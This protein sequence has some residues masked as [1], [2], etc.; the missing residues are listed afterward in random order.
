MTAVSQ[1]LAYEI[2]PI[3][4]CHLW[5]GDRGSNGRPIIWRGRRPSSAYRVAFEHAGEVVADDQVLDHL[6]RRERCINAAHLEAV[7][8]AENERRKSW[9]YRCRRQHCARGHSLADAL[10]TPE[11]GRL[12]RI[13]LLGERARNSKHG[14]RSAQ[15]AESAALGPDSVKQAAHEA[16]P[17]SE[18]RSLTTPGEGMP[19][20]AGRPDSLAGDG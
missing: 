9:A 18:Q 1:L 16:I 15:Q 19:S 2:D 11:G 6:C 14:E 10:V 17:N 8:K 5:T 7:S 13:C 20:Y 3:Y 4:G 12:C